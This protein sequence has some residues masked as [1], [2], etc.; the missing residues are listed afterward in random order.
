MEGPPVGGDG[1]QGRSRHGAGTSDL[2]KQVAPALRRSG[3]RARARQHAQRIEAEAA[4]APGGGCVSRVVQFNKKS[5]DLRAAPPR[6]EMDRDHVE[7]HAIERGIKIVHG[8]DAHARRVRRFRDLQHDGGGTAVQIV[9]NGIIRLVR[10]GERNALRDMPRRRI[11]IPRA[12][13]GANARRHAA[14]ALARIERPD[15]DIVI[16][17]PDQTLVESLALEHAFDQRQP[18]R[19]GGGRKFRTEWQVVHSLDRAHVRPLTF[20][21]HAQHAR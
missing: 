17:V 21:G 8:P 13:P 3:N 2:R 11:R 1:L 12:R 4:P 9:K 20:G 7:M 5:C 16:A 6:I 10:P 14:V 19:V 15:R 18:V